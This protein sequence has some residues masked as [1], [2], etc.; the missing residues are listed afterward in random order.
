MVKWNSP[1]LISV[2]DIKSRAFNPT[3][4]S[5]G[6]RQSLSKGRLTGAQVALEGHH[7]AGV[8]ELG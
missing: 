8:N 4:N 1:F 2:Q 3:R 5:Q 7:Q 6:F